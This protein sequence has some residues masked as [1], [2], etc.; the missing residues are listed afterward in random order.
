MAGRD[1]P[2][3]AAPELPPTAPE[4]PTPTAGLTAFL[5]H[6]RDTYERLIGER[7]GLI[8]HAHTHIEQERHRL[9]PAQQALQELAGFEQ[10]AA[11]RIK[12]YNATINELRS[13]LDGAPE[14]PAA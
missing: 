3:P 14:K 8:V 1:A 5:A 2:P 10:A 12:A 11:T 9:A 7:D 6:V 4:T 13:L